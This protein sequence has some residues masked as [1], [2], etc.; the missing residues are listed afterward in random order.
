MI[1]A[2]NRLAYKPKYELIADMV[3]EA[4]LTGVFKN[5]DR[6]PPDVQLAPRYSVNT[7]TLA[8]GLKILVDE[9]LLARAPR[10]GTI[11]IYDEHATP[12]TSNAVGMVMLS[13]G[14]VYS[15]INRSLSSELTRRKLFPALV[16]NQIVGDP[17]GLKIFMNAMVDDEIKPYGFVIDGAFEFP[18]DFLKEKIKKFHNV[19]FITKYHYSEKIQP[20]KYVLVDYAEAGR[21]A[22][23][24]FIS[25]GH[26]KLA[27]LA[28]HE[29]GYVAPWC[30]MQVLIMRGFAEVCYSAG[31]DFSADIFWQLLHGAPLDETVGRMLADENRP[32]AIFSYS[33]MFVRE[34]IIPLLDGH[35]LKPMEDIELMDFYDTPHSEKYG[36][37][38]IGIREEE[39]AKQA[40]AML[41]GENV[42]K[43]ILIK[44]EL[45]IRSNNK[46]SRKIRECRFPRPQMNSD[47]V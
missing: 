16:N 34:K 33:D 13:E 10:R 3:R 32:T 38:S 15:D 7:R 17:T 8:A 27:C 4:I 44:P 18:F 29:P 46:N 47:K 21:L 42:Q 31:V 41:C 26:E 35:G 30:S 1:S 2:G 5:G 22:A 45:I 43:E 11:V 36:I 14:D 6:L 25:Q 37:S 20:A 9:G 12:K 40:V 39:I 24:H 19:V 28:M 23:R